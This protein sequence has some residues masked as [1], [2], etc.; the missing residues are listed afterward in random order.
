MVDKVLNLFYMNDKKEPNEALE[1]SRL[2]VTNRAFSPL[3][4]ARFAPSNRLAQLE[5]SAPNEHQL[6]KGFKF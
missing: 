6:R 2:L 3:R 1:R 4:G 5:R